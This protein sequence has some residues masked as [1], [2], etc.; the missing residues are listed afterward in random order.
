M[1][2]EIPHIS[3][4]CKLVQS[5]YGLFDLFFPS[6]HVTLLSQTITLLC[7]EL[8]KMLGAS[9]LWAD[10]RVLQILKLTVHACNKA[11]PFLLTCF[12]F[13]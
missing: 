10:F 12:T 1:S 9:S 4:S 6:S 13:T 8:Y 7:G 5:K 11:I 3:H 2:F